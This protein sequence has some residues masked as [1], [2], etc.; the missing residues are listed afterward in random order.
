MSWNYRV[1]VKT[2]PDGTKTYGIHEVYYT[3]RGKTRTCTVDEVSPHGETLRELKSDFSM[4]RKA[5]SAPVLDYKTLK[6][7]K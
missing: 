4:M 6:E 7:P 1:V 2:Y 3:A 5:L